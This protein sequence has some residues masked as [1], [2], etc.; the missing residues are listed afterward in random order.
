MPVRE[1]VILSPAMTAGAPGRRVTAGPTAAIGGAASRGASDSD[2]CHL[3]AMSGP[4]PSL[5][6]ESQIPRLGVTPA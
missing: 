5:S 4:R 1:P 6:H 2:D 3:H